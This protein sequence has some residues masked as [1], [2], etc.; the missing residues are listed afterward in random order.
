MKT[1]VVCVLV[2]CLVVRLGAPA[3]AQPP[4]LALAGEWSVA[5]DLTGSCCFAG[6]CMDLV[7]S[8]G[9][10][11]LTQNNCNVCLNPLVCGQATT[12]HLQLSGPL[13]LC[14]AG[15]ETENYFT[16]EGPA[17]TS[18]FHLT[19]SGAVQCKVQGISVTC[20]A[21][22]ANLDGTRPAPTSIAY[23][24]LGDSYSSGEGVPSYFNGTD[25]KA[26]PVTSRNRCHRS[27]R[28]YPTLVK[29]PA[30]SKTI[31]QLSTDPQV[32]G[33]R[34]DFLACS[35]ATTANV[36]IG[37]AS[38]PLSGTKEGPQ[39]DRMRSDGSRV[40]DAD[41]SLVSITIG[42]DDIYFGPVLELCFFKKDCTTERRFLG[43]DLGRPL[44]DQVQ[45]WINAAARRLAI[46][47]R[48]IQSIA[49]NARIVVLGYPRLFSG[50]SCVGALRFSGEEQ[51]FLNKG[52]DDL[53]KAIAEVAA[54]SGV[55]YVDVADG[56]NSFSGHEVCGF[57]D[58]IQGINFPKSS[59]FHP[60]R[61]G[62][63]AYAR[64]FNTYLAS[65]PISAPQSGGKQSA[66]G[67]EGEPVG[68]TFGSM[69]IEAA[70]TPACTDNRAYVL[71]QRVRITG[72]GFAAGAMVEVGFSPIEEPELS[73]GTL[74][75]GETGELDGVL[76]IPGDLK[77]GTTLVEAV[78]LGF[79]AIPH[80][81]VT[82]VSI[83]ESLNSDGDADTV[84]DL[85]DNCPDVQNGEQLDTDDDSVGDACDPCSSDFEDR[86][87]TQPC[88][89][90]CNGNGSVA[91]NELI[92]G[93]NLALGTVPSE[94]CS[95]FF[96]EGGIAVP[97]NCLVSAVNHSL[98]GCFSN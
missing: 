95:A 22:M 40:L 44:K 56:S 69:T 96:C 45:P 34:W 26:G 29:L 55:E 17:S 59:S 5:L 72:S 32:S 65:F 66:S 68:I 78:G 85:C 6:R 16:V 61:D 25:E 11:A 73:G 23:A 15:T 10:T 18:E 60:N 12:D 28:A 70:D 46:V 19:G 4:C 97:I 67:G 89:G 98:N 77:P 75:A 80:I 52:A 93:V 74:P 84:P 90:D 42:G 62:Q 83:G 35:G 48:D 41:T 47:Y 53:N 43:V 50:R 8:M 20:T 79:D 87:T 81:L 30:E 13:I 57:P 54:Q 14:D 1:P 58:W 33:V 21:S 63:A 24:A 7:D 36:V 27:T 91:I 31:Y 64:L 51:T 94:P 71:G 9:D 88:V 92:T 38:A 39:L 76:V 86:C 37:G 82:T 2:A 49:P 3:D